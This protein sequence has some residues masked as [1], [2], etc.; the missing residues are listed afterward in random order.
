[1]PQIALV[2]AASQGIGAAT[3]RELADDGFQ[4]VLMARSDS[5]HTLAREL[6]GRA[7]TGSVTDPGDLARLVGGSPNT[8]GVPRRMYL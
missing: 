8:C 2:T 3:A 7:V 1:M 6:G 5:V 4:V